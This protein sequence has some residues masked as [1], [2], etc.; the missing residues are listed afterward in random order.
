MSK[1]FSNST[2]PLAGS[3]PGPLISISA[4]DKG[5]WRCW[6]KRPFT[7]CV[8]GWANPFASG[9]PHTWPGTSLGPSKAMCVSTTTPSWSPTI[10]LHTKS[11]YANTTNIPP[12]NSNKKASSL[13]SP[14]SMAS[15]L[16]S[17][18]DSLRRSD[19]R[20]VKLSPAPKS[21]PEG[22]EDSAQGFNPGNRPPA[23]RAL[24][25]A[26]DQTYKKHKV[27]WGQVKKVTWGQVK[28]S[29]LLG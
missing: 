3:G 2:R 20:S 5:A 8:I 17:A 7:R 26:P 16:I 13:H 18:S 23:R 10:T 28:C 14:G 21:L 4:T 6:L 27:T 11:D 25:G 12:T 1:S 9:T 19:P 22:L 29:W 24:K 15:N